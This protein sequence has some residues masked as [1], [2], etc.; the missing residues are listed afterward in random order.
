MAIRCSQRLAE[1]LF[2]E[3]EED[4]IVIAQI[5]APKVLLNRFWQVVEF[6]KVL[7]PPPQ[8]ALSYSNQST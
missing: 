4:D 8:F 5:I 1:C 7:S 3:S 2:E 6:G